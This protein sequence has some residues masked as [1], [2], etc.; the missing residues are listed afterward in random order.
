[1]E[2]W[3]KLAAVDRSRYVHFIKTLTMLMY[4]GVVAFQN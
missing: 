2:T 1:M 3:Q 4:D